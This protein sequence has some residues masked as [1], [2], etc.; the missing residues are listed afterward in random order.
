MVVGYAA[1]MYTIE[2]P[3]ATLPALTV[4]GKSD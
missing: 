3:M 4:E 2:P 1:F